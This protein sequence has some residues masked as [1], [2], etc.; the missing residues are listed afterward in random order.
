MSFRSDTVTAWQAASVDMSDTYNHIRA[1]VRGERLADDSVSVWHATL[2]VGSHASSRGFDN[3]G[4]DRF[5]SL[6]DHDFT[7]DGATYTITNLAHL[8]RTVLALDLDKVLLSTAYNDLTLHL[9]TVSE[10]DL[11]ETGSTTRSHGWT[12]NVPSWTSGDTIKVGLTAKDNT[13]PSLESASVNAAGDT[14]TLDFDENIDQA[15][16][17]PLSAFA[18][19][20]SPEDVDFGRPATVSSVSAG[21]NADQLDLSI[22]GRLI[23]AS[24]VVTVIYTDPTGDDDPDAVQDAADNDAFS[25]NTAAEGSSAVVNGSTVP[26]NAAPVFAPS[27]AARSVPENSPAGTFVGAPVAAEDNDLDALEYTLGGTDAASFAIDAGT[28]QISTVAAL[29]YETKSSYSV[30]VTANDSI[31]APVPIDVTISVIDLVAISATNTDE[32]AYPVPMD[33]ALIPTGV[34]IGG[35]FRLLFMTST[36]RDASSTDIDDYNRFVQ[37]AAVSGHAAIQDYSHA[38]RVV[39][40]TKTVHARDN[41]ATTYTDEDKGVAIYWL[42]GTKVVDDYEDFYDGSWDDETNLK[43]ESGAARAYTQELHRPFTGSYADGTA[44]ALDDLELGSA[45]PF[46]TS[47]RYEVAVGDLGTV[48]DDVDTDPRDGPI[49]TVSVFGYRSEL[50]PFYGLSPVFRVTNVKPVFADSTPARSVPENS[51]AG[52]FVGDPVTATDVDGHGLTYTLG[53]T[54]AASFAIDAGTGQISTAAALDYETKSSYSVTVTVDDGN[55]GTVTIDVTISV[56]DLVAISATS[57]GEQAYPVPMDWALIPTGVGAGG[58]FR[59]L[60]ITSTTRD[61]SSADIDDYNRFV[62]AAA[63]GGHAAI[64]DYSHAF[65][66]VGSTVTVHARDNTATTYTATDKGVPIYWLSGNKVADDYED[67]YDESWDDEANSKRESGAAHP[68]TATTHLPFTGSN[69]DGTGALTDEAYLGVPNTLL[70]IQGDPGDLSEEAGDGPIYS[71]IVALS[72]ASRPFYGLS[73]V[74]RV[75]G[76]PP[77]MATAPGAPTGLSA[78]ANGQ[79][80]IDLSWTAPASNGGAAI[81]GYKIE[82]SSDAGSTWSNLVANT[83]STATTY[84][85]TT[86]LT[87]GTTRHY[88]VSAINS[89]GTSGLSNVDSATTAAAT[90]P[91]APTGLSATANGQTRIDLSWTAPAS[92]GG[93][94]ITGYKIEVSSDAGSIWTD[95]EANTGSTGTTY[96]HTGLSAGTTRHYRVSAIN[97]AGTSGVSNVDSA[98]TGTNRA[99]EFPGT[100]VSRSVPENTSGGT[101]IGSPVAAIDDDGDTLTYTLEGA[102]RNSFG[103]VSTSGQIRTKS[104]VDYDHEAAKN[105]YSVTVKADDGK[106]GTDTIAVT[107]TVTDVDEPPSAP[108]MPTVSPTSGSPASLDVSWTAPG[109]NG[110][111]ALTGYEPALLGR[112]QQQLE[113]AAA[114]RPGHERGHRRHLREHFLR[115]AGARPQRRNA[116]RVVAFRHRDHERLRR[117]RHRSPPRAA[118]G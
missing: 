27:A 64:Q 26:A 72:S 19:I 113:P 12:A 39:G 92:D 13:R 21:T 59:L 68:V 7:Y 1:A 96:S 80:R 32:L 35:S 91:G 52:T 47:G 25:F 73:P 53:G 48:L 84:S 107:I 66:V 88:R 110:G 10:Y 102:D 44:A 9:G 78:T 2:V 69:H 83:A 65:R 57:T 77:I 38:F 50:H 4:A 58:S 117:T 101:N 8:G 97:L 112:R 16:L 100:S 17:P 54:D 24:E 63:A 45:N 49:Y 20:L 105:S 31:A 61:A 18:V 28:G 86:G 55:G 118:A 75:R 104:G 56:I 62:Q 3:L 51:P 87:A 81:S 22:A 111:P 14:I 23:R 37:A 76:A 89:A 94:P 103:I 6:S 93:S 67:F 115:R 79:T 40:S 33:W 108:A 82:V 42:G 43:S 29:D 98:T 30:T 11:S 106:S 60:F 116:E 90:A 5:G 15:N 41:T 46:I 71:A 99:P 95:L 109:R 74:F 114:Q 85:Q 34:S 36:T 70:V